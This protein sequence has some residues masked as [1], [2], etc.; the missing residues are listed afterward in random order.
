VVSVVAGVESLLTPTLRL[1][2]KGTTAIRNIQGLKWFSELGIHPVWNYLSHVPG[3]RADWLKQ[4][5]RLIPR[6]MHLT[7]PLPSRI[8]VERDSPYHA[9]PAEHGIEILG[10]ERQG[11]LA[12]AELAP[13]LV[14]RLSHCFECRILGRDPE[15]DAIFEATVRP[16]LEEWRARF[17]KRGCT[18][19]IVHGPVESLV[20]RGPFFTPERLVRVRG[21]LRGILLAC[22]G[23]Q[24]EG[25]LSA[26]LEGSV[27]TEAVPAALY[28]Q[29][30]STLACDNPPPLGEGS[31]EEMLAAAEADGLIVRE[32]SQVLAL[33]VNRT[34]YIQGSACQRRLALLRLRKALSP[35]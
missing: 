27:A 32:G 31:L 5:E 11:E 3:E 22:E 29:L 2:R 1:M 23:V 10:P 24:S 17:A 13:E 25:S 18:L 33:P 9:H 21:T 4:L 28:A 35:G 19:S 34:A 8:M 15:V 16:L 6:L 26:A 20:I 14:E 7:P 30:L 12:F